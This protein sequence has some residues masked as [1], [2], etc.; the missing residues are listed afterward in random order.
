[1]MQPIQDCDQLQYFRYKKHMYVW[2][3]DEA[4]YYRV[5]GLDRSASLGMFHKA[6]GGLTEEEEKRR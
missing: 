2:D 6:K 3:P 1:M 5:L 4:S